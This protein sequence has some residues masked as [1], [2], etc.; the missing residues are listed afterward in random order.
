MVPGDARGRVA[1]MRRSGKYM[2]YSFADFGC[3][4]VDDRRKQQVVVAKEEKEMGW[5]FAWRHN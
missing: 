5:M 3:S 1:V 4:F 2:I